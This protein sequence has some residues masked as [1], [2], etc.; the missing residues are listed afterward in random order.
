V[1]SGITVTVG[2]SVDGL[3][4]SR[5]PEQPILAVS[6]GMGEFA[7]RRSRDRPTGFREVSDDR[8][9]REIEFLDGGVRHTLI[10]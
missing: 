5:L 4:E 8:V 6:F 1:T 2:D 7:R 10:E 9:K 3:D